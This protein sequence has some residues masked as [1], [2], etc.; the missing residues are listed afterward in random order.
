METW[1]LVRT[2]HRS[3][4]R[5]GVS[6]VLALHLSTDRIPLVPDLSLRRK[7]SSGLQTMLFM[8]RMEI[9][10]KQ[11]IFEA[12]RSHSNQSPL[13]SPDSLDLCW[14]LR[15]GA[16][17]QREEGPLL[18]LPSRIK[19]AHYARQAQVCPSGAPALISVVK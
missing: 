9:D 18:L 10:S 11:D 8:S 1:D 14:P 2:G 3:L 6:L 7:G 13:G 5:P 16:S 12:P 17:V 4:F 15:G 19:S